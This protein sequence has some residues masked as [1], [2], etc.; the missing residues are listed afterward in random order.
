M[1]ASTS[2]AAFSAGGEVVTLG[3]QKL[4][5]RNAIEHAQEQFLAQV[6]IEHPD[7]GEMDIEPL[8]FNSLPPMFAQSTMVYSRSAD[9]AAMQIFAPARGQTEPWRMIVTYSMRVDSAFLLAEG[10]AKGTV[11]MSW[12]VKGRWLALLDGEAS[13]STVLTVLEPPR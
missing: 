5:F 1:G 9:E 13:T 10:P 12:S 8:G 6:A 11:T 7:Q 3:S 2:A 4:T